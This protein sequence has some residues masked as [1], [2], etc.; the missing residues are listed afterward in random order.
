MI[1]AQPISPAAL[2]GIVIGNFIAIGIIRC[3]MIKPKV[4]PAS[5]AAASEISFVL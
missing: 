3:L 4:W 2:A 5:C 1:G